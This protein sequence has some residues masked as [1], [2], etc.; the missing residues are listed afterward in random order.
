MKLFLLFTLLIT[1]LAAQTGRSRPLTAVGTVWINHI[2]LPSGASV[3]SGDRVHTAHDSIALFQD[4]LAGRVEVRPSSSVYFREQAL[5][6]VDGSV[7]SAGPAVTVGESTIEPLAGEDVWF[8][9]AEHD[10]ETWVAAYEGSVV[11]S[12]PGAEALTLAAGTYATTAAL[13]A[14]PR[15]GEPRVA[16]QSSDRSER[17]PSDKS[18]TRRRRPAAGQGRSGGGKGASGAASKGGWSIGGLGSTAS[19]VVL[20]AVGAGAVVGVTLG[21][22][23]LLDEPASPSQ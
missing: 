18:T 21:V 3:R 6:L 23:R 14:L 12:A 16:Q 15:A 8:V 4:Q 2:A 5:E 17:Q 11:I 19:T 9:V 7:G 22:V 10:G 1:P 20:A 13:A